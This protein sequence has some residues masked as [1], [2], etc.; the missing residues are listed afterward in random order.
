[1]TFRGHVA[2]VTGGASG[3]GRLAVRRLA[4]AGA[5][6]VAVDVDEE[7]L[8]QTAARNDRTV[9]R[10]VDVTDPDAVLLLAKEVEAE[11]G[12]IDRLVT[13]AAI[14]PTGPLLEQPL[15]EIH[16]VM[17]INYGGT[18]NAI[19]AVV[20]TMVE[21]DRGDVVIFASLAG[22]FPAPGFGA[23]S[24]TKFAT[25]ALAETLAMEL[26]ASALRVCCVCP[27]IVDTP[28]LDQIGDEHL[29]G[30]PKLAP[31]VVLD[32]IEDALER[33]RL[34]TFPGPAT[35]TLVRAR[36]FLPGFVRRRLISLND[37]D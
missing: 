37:P 28:L 11:Y 17:D 1:M 7:G 26:H 8:A 3:M 14:A 36:K 21:R 30:Q 34:Y 18:V 25:V 4:A 5:T 10:V 20:P 13:A 9:T 12:S 27:P 24:A 31:E 19:R 29:H 35:S 2:L 33:G 15:D 32:A 22:W 6:V 23:Y 16:R